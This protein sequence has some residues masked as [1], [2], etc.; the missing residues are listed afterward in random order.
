[1][2]AIALAQPSGEVFICRLMPKLCACDWVNRATAAKQQTT[3][4]KIVHVR[5]CCQHHPSIS[6]GAL[7]GFGAGWCVRK[8]MN[9]PF[10]LPAIYYSHR[11]G[12]KSS[13]LCACDGVRP[14]DDEFNLYENSSDF[15]FGPCNFRCLRCPLMA[16]DGFSPVTG[17]TAT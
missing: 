8:L 15:R 2:C 13:L 16:G 17:L 1:M 6:G 11:Y 9:F 7:M 10:K 5:I 3:C 14:T 12:I 4:I